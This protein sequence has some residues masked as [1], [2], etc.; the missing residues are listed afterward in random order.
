MAAG[1][2]AAP[3]AKRRDYTDMFS[4]NGFCSLPFRKIHEK[5]SAQD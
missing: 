5:R 4:T 3:S 2:V 1:E